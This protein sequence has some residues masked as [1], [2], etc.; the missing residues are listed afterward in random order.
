[1]STNNEIGVINI[2]DSKDNEGAKMDTEEE[3]KINLIKTKKD[4]T[5]E[6]TNTREQFL[7]EHLSCEMFH[8]MLN[9]VYS[10]DLILKFIYIF[11]ILLGLGMSSFINVGLILTYLQYN[12]NTLTRN[13]NEVPSVFPKVTICNSNFFTTQLAYEYLSGL[14]LT[15]IQLGDRTNA[16]TEYFS[17]KTYVIGKVQYYPDELKKKF[18]HN[19]ND[20]LLSCFFNLKPCSSSDFQWEWD[21][22]YGNC[23][24]FNTGFDSSGQ[25]VELRKA[26][27]GGNAFSL[28]IEFYVNFYEEL[29]FFNS[30]INDYGL[31]IRV[32]NQ[33]HVIDYQHGGIFVSAGTSNYLALNRQFKTSLPKPYSECEDLS[34]GNYPSTLYNLIIH[35]KYDY[36]QQF[37]L[38]QC[39]QELTIKTCN[40]SDIDSASLRNVS[41]CASLNQTSCILYKAYYG[42]YTKNDYVQTVCLPQCPLECNSTLMI[43]MSF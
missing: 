41:S 20:T 38:Q 34:S 2:V 1:M 4:M 8:F 35:S 36:T 16:L 33:S 9:V 17:L 13:I 30:I 11:F 29:K 18:S 6:E 15:Q 23:F 12:V 42:I 19:L 39:L 28:Q 7:L 25:R 21:Y 10:S 32:D 40:C 3:N 26:F 43:K 31:I 5:K 27:I 24:S 14:N 37:C 22:Y